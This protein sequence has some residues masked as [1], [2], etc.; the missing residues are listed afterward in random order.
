MRSFIIF[1]LLCILGYAGVYGA[2][3]ALPIEMAVH[4][5][6][7]LQADVGRVSGLLT[8]PTSWPEWWNS[9]SYV[10]RQVSATTK[11]GQSYE[12]VTRYGATAQILD[13][14]TNDPSRVVIGLR[15][16]WMGMQGGIGITLTE[17]EG[18]TFIKVSQ[19]VKVESPLWRCFWYYLAGKDKIP[20]TLLNKLADHLNQPDA[21]IEEL[22]L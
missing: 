8:P 2:G 3:S 1:I 7:F 19:I 18:Q 10:S 4:R 9:I 12:V 21:T 6:M 16:T 5:G 20:N 22:V 15:Q 17:K 14:E 11:K 13:A